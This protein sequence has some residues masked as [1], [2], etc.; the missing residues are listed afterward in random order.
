MTKNPKHFVNFELNWNVVE[1]AGAYT[2]ECEYNTDLFDAATAERWVEHYCTL[3][4]V[5]TL[6]FDIHALEVWLPLVVGARVEIVPREET[7][8]GL[9][10]LER[11]E[12]SQATVLQATPTTWRLL[13]AAGWPGDPHLKAL[14]G[15]EAMPVGLADQLRP[16]VGKL[17]NMYGPTETTV[18]STVH[19]VETTECPI[20]IGRPIANTSVF[21]L[22]RN[23][24]PVPIGVAGDLWIGGDGL[25]RG[26]RDRPELTAQRF[27]ANETLAPPGH[28]LYRTG[29]QAR[30]R[31]DG[32]IECLGRT[33]EPSGVI[34]PAGSSMAGWSC[35][36]PR[37]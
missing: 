28:R 21:I 2:L 26:Y 32:V 15:G 18:W 29:D 9:A 8:D 10:L 37:M 34:G 25:A 36:G 22:D 16:R 23:L 4:A 6:A 12:R 27:I 35:S 11:L 1:E 30:Y 3:L 14:C 20:P 33:D 7:A 13:L 5:T 24:Q 17:W 19:H 31:P